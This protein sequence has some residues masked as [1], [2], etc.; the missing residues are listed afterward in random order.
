MVII[1]FCIQD[2]V[3]G[4]QAL[5]QYAAL[6]YSDGLDLTVTA[7]YPNSV[8]PIGTFEITDD[9]SLLVQEEKLPDTS[10]VNIEISGQGCFVLQVCVCL[11]V[12]VFVYIRVLIEVA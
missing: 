12:C 5:A 6:V 11:Y 3:I 9:N 8:S 7:S 10:P 4:L 1:M 2:T